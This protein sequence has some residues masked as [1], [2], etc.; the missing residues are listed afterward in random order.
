MA[1]RTREIRARVDDD[2]FD[3]VAHE[4]KRLGVSLS[5]LIRLRILGLMHPAQMSAPN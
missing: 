3:R 4:A 2:E 5:T 1:K